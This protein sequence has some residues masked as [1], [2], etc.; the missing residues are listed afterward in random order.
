MLDYPHQN[1]ILA[2]QRLACVLVPIRLPSLRSAD[3]RAGGDA[4]RGGGGREGGG[5]GE[6]EEEEQG[7]ERKRRIH[8]CKWKQE[9]QLQIQ[10]LG[11]VGLG[12][13]HKREKTLAT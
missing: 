13:R 1:I 3:V 7:R 9:Q 5:G 4:L 12:R 10:F 8:F 11:L 6:E 2:L